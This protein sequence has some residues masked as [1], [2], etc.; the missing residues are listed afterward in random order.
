MESTEVTTTTQDEVVPFESH[1][2][3]PWTLLVGGTSRGGEVVL[4]H[5]AKEWGC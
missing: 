5:M 2:E 3:D 4:E 1:E